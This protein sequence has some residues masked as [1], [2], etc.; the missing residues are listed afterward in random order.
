MD[1]I[2]VAGGAFILLAGAA[3][4]ALFVALPIIAALDIVRN[5]DRYQYPVLMAGALIATIPIL[6]GGLLGVA[7]Y[8]LRDKLTVSRSR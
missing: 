8:L 3:G 4:L 5:R 2:G 7:Y 6:I 1:G